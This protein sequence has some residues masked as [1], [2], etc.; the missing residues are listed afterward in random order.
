MSATPI[1]PNQPGVPQH[2]GHTPYKGP[3]MPYLIQHNLLAHQIITTHPLH[4]A[5]ILDYPTLAWL[6]RYVA[7]PSPAGTRRWLQ[8]RDMLDEAG[9]E[10]GTRARAKGCL[11][12]YCIAAGKFS[13]EEVEEL[14]KWFFEGGFPDPENLEGVE[15]WRR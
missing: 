9:E 2:E 14:R 11:I 5:N 15:P 12:G 8:E 13:W 3:S 10:R 6:R 7:D 4:P 1:P